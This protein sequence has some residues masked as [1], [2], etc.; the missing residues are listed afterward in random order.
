MTIEWP[1]Y[2]A[3]TLM[4]LAVAY[5]YCKGRKASLVSGQSLAWTNIPLIALAIISIGPSI[6]AVILYFTY[7]FGLVQPSPPGYRFGSFVYFL[8]ADFAL[9]NWAFVPLYVVCRVWPNRD[10]ARPA[11]WF[12]VVAMSVPAAVLFGLAPEMISSA[13]DAGQGIGIIEAMLLWPPIAMIVPGIASMIIDAGT[14]SMFLLM[15]LTGLLPTL[16]LMAWLMGQFAG[17]MVP[18]PR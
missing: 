10:A 2:L 15:A 17:R 12:S 3:L 9:I 8:P 14:S 18:K 16:G 13:F 5:G 11:M 1:R 4:V 7:R 6:Y